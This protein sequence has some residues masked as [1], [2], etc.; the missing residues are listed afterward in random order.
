MMYDLNTPGPDRQRSGGRVSPK[1]TLPLVSD[2]TLPLVPDETP[3]RA[4]GSSILSTGSLPD[5][6]IISV[7]GDRDGPVPQPIPTGATRYRGRYTRWIFPGSGLSGRPGPGKWGAPPGQE[8][9]GGTNPVG[10]RS[11]DPPSPSLS[12]ITGQSRADGDFAVPVGT[13]TLSRGIPG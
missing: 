9:R 2:E 5:W 1:P 7:R 13:D 10:R 12:G 3:G 11:L 6:N 4:G 8:G